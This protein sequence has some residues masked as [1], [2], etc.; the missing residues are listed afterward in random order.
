MRSSARL[1]ILLDSTY[2]LPI[3]GVEVEGIESGLATLRKLRRENRATFHYTPFNILECLGKITKLEYDHSTV[4]TGLSLIEE[5]FEQVSPST[6]GYL[7]ALELRKRGFKGLIDLLLF[8]TAAGEN[9][10][11]LTRDSDLIRFLRKSGENLAAILY[12]EDFLKMFR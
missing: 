7:K 12:E 11:F 8:V 9:L 1:R 3:L 10:L 4:A 5:E 6:L 2:L